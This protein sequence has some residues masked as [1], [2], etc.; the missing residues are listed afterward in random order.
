MEQLME[1][2]LTFKL[3]KKVS[4]NKRK[5]TKVEFFPTEE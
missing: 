2:G 3:S 5:Y 4:T 1:Y